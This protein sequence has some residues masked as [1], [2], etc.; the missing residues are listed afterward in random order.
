MRKPIPRKES[1]VKTTTQKAP[2]GTYQ[3]QK[4]MT[5]LL[6]ALIV[7]LAICA[8]FVYY[9]IYLDETSFEQ[10]GVTY[11]VQKSDG[12]YVLMNEDGK[13]CELTSDG[14]YVTDDGKL[15]ISVSAE[16]GT[17]SIYAAVEGLEDGE[18]VYNLSAE[19]ILIFPYVSQSTLQALEMHNEHGVYSI[20]CNE[21]GDFCVT[22]TEESLATYDATALSALTTSTCGMIAQ[23]KIIDP[24]VD[25][26]GGYSEYGLTDTDTYWIV[27]TID[28]DVYKMIL[29]DKTPA[30]DGYYVQY[31]ACSNVTLDGDGRV[32]SMIETPRAA[33]YIVSPSVLG[34]S[35]DG[36]SIEY[37]DKPF[38]NAVESLLIPQITYEMSTSTYFD[39]SNFI[40]MQ[41]N[42]ALLAF[43]YIDIATRAHTQEHT[44]PFAMLLQEHQGLTLSSDKVM[45]ALYSLYNMS[46]VGC[47]KLNP[48]T[49]DLIEYGIY[50]NPTL[51]YIDKTNTVYYVTQQEDGTYALCNKDLIPCETNADGDYLT[52]AGEIVRIYT[53]TNDDGTVSVSGETVLGSG[54]WDY[55]YTSPYSIFFNFDITE[56]GTNYTTEQFVVF[57]AK[58][59][60]R[61]SYYAYSPNYNMIVEIASYDL[62]FLHWS[63]FDWIDSSL[64]QVNIV[65]TGT[66]T[67]EG[68]DGTV[69]SFKLNNTETS[70]AKLTAITNGTYTDGN[71]T[72][73]VLKKVDGVYGLYKST[74][75]KHT[76]STSA[77]FRVADKTAETS[78]LYVSY[79][80]LPSGGKSEGWFAGQFYLTSD[81]KLLLCD[82][83]NGYYAVADV[84][85]ASSEL[86]VLY[87]DSHFVDT[88]NFRQL[89]KSL[90]FASIE[91]EYH[92]TEEEESALI[93]NPAKFQLRITAKTAEK[94]LV[95]EFYYL[96]SRKS[97]VR[98]SGDG[99]ET[100]IG[101]MYVLTARVNKMLSDSE[102]LLAGIDIDA[103]AKN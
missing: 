7:V 100:F 76:A 39:V 80:G 25:E 13:I 57:S 93:A 18:E 69:Y 75:P 70:L 51:C 38:H 24:L 63:L 95:Y 89:Y 8:A 10:G 26:N 77:Y 32:V 53:K 99:G 48:S 86:T 27:T 64:Y 46:F 61:N 101:G 103:E 55:N 90:T 35:S 60:D 92:L 40:L 49:E 43:D 102:K 68:P 96:T 82:T 33:V 52:S 28:G 5:I 50:V 47:V 79:F 21:Y 16:D 6:A 9:L 30:G 2:V 36:T 37:I 58:N 34:Y 91:Q 56:N 73:Y 11:R 78:E 54:E 17:Y 71:G 20:Y 67:I 45:D 87:N 22:G 74:G 62:E 15:L 72:K 97:Y 14:Y 41:G 59:E 4:R 23:D 29:G 65:F 84:T 1:H 12:S 98:I 88:D 31:I 85:L 94:E 3:K 83:E 44:N 42:D 66:F 81:N 19:T